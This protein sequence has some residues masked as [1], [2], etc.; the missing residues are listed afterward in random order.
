MT[1]FEQF[2]HIA[3]QTIFQIFHTLFQDFRITLGP[4]VLI[5]C[6]D[7]DHAF[8]PFFI[9]GFYTVQIN[10]RKEHFRIACLFVIAKLQHFQ[11]YR[12]ILLAHLNQKAENRL[13]HG[14]A[15]PAYI[16]CTNS[17]SL[18]RGDKPLCKVKVSVVSVIGQYIPCRCSPGLSHKTDKPSYQRLVL[19]PFLPDESI[20]QTILCRVVKPCKILTLHFL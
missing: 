16:F 12:R 9:Q 5:P 14:A 17:G 4:V 18:Y 13:F 2:I 15:V 10:C 20:I 19:F 8:S 3:H 7:T 11:K 1:G 6:R